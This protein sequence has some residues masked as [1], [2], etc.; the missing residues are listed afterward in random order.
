MVTVG[1]SQPTNLQSEADGASPSTG[2]PDIE[3][4]DIE[5][6]Q[7]S[8]EENWENSPQNPY[9]WSTQS[10][11]LQVSLMASAAFTT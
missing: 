5:I 7:N 10:K 4:G 8:T 1:T 9:N 6:T 11:I 2:A 3:T